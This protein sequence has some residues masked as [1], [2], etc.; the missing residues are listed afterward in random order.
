VVRLKS[1]YIIRC[2][3]FEKDEA[4]NVTKVMAEYIPESKSGSD[5]S[6]L[7]AKGTIHWISA[8]HAVTAEIRLYDRLFKVEDPS[9]EEGDFKEYINENSL[10]IIQHAYIEPELLKA[11]QG[12]RFQFIRKGYFTLDAVHS[13]SKKLVF[14]RTVTLKD[15]WS[16]GGK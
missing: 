12:D 11:N 13:N 3:G 1:A 8:E 16:K 9:S 14:N 4:G 6:G 5:T 2:T 15:T 7:S 10:T